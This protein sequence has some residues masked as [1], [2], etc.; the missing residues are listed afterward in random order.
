MKKQPK[1]E[2]T[3]DYDLVEVARGEFDPSVYLT[4]EAREKAIAE[5]FKRLTDGKEYDAE[6]YTYSLE[7]GANGYDDGPYGEI[8]F[9]EKVPKKVDAVAETKDENPLANMTDKEIEE[10]IQFLYNAGNVSG[11]YDEDH[12]DVKRY[13][14][15]LAERDRRRNASKADIKDVDPLTMMSDAEIKE[16]IEDLYNRGIASGEYDED[17]PDVKRYWE[18]VD[19]QSR[20][21]KAAQDLNPL[22]NM[23]DKEIE[24]EIK[25]L[26]N[27]GI[28]SGEYDEDHPDVKRYHEL[29]DEQSRRNKAKAAAEA[30]TNSEYEKMTSEDLLREY[31][32]SANSMASI[33]GVDPYAGIDEVDYETAIG[34]TDED[35]ENFAALKEQTSKKWLKSAA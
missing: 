11:E 3:V 29:A 10:E 35:K 9:F 15:L 19:E 18:L 31:I 30:A 6:K 22:A 1:V 33:L 7:E 14:E 28:T 4:E 26:Y 20:R 24:E 23:T 5:E 2:D 16:E 8:M 25:D 34:L 27:R 13:H 21:K 12:P 17:H 32:K